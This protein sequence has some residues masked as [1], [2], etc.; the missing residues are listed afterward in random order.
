MEAATI[1]EEVRLFFDSFVDAFPTFKGENI[2]HLYAVPY[3]AIHSDGA[4]EVHASHE[5]IRAYFQGV[6]NAYRQRG[7]TGCRYDELSVNDMGR[8]AVVATVHWELTGKG[9]DV[10]SSWR[11]SYHLVRAESLW[12]IR[13]STD[14]A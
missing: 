10:L 8:N 6:L 3:M 13:V 4:A 2:A 1:R 5:S 12:K 9:G 11:E 7:C 14:H